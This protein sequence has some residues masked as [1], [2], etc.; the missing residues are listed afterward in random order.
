MGR[1]FVEDRPRL[2]CVTVT[3]AVWVGLSVLSASEGGIGLSWDAINHHIYLGWTATAHRLDQDFLA[4]NLQSL[5]PPYSYLPAYLLAIHGAGPV[6]AATVLSALHA[7]AAPGL[8]LIARSL[9]PGS[10]WDAVA[11]RGLS[12][13]LGYMSPVVLSLTDNTAND[14][15]SAIPLVWAVA[16]ATLALDPDL[17]GPRRQRLTLMSGLLAGVAVGL[18]LSNGPLVLLMPLLWAWRGP[19]LSAGAARVASAS[20][21][22]LAGY[23][24]TYG[25]WGWLLWQ[26]FGN[27][28]YPFHDAWFEPVRRALGWGA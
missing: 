15:L 16:L 22:L 24:V 11:L 6:L 5:Q 17:H 23:A 3:L 12:V 9:L 7:L 25:Y 19:S 27:P 28:L 10:G 20:G 26:R 14:L 2:E 1:S 18:K 8:W 4:A 21:A 13:L